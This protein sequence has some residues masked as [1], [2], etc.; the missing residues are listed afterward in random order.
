MHPPRGSHGS[1]STLDYYNQNLDALYVHELRT[2]LGRSTRG[3]LD[4]NKLLAGPRFNS[5]VRRIIYLWQAKV[6]FIYNYRYHCI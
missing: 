3:S 4:L 6:T 5:R 1:H 2:C